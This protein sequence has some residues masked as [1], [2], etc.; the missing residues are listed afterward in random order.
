MKP[1]RKPPKPPLKPL[2]PPL[3]PQHRQPAPSLPPTPVPP[4]QQVRHQD[5]TEEKFHGLRACEALFARRSQDIIR[6]YLTEERRRQFVKLLDFCAK[7]RRGFQ[8]VAPENLQRLTGSIHHEGIAILAREI[9][10]WN[11]AELMQAIESQRLDGPLLYLDGV[12]NPHNLGTIL[13]TAA[14][15]GVAAILGAAS[16]LPSLSP[17]AVRVAEGAAECVPVCVLVDPIADLAR[18]KKAGFRVVATSSHR[19]D[20]IHAATIIKKSILVLGGEG[21]GVS[22]PID[23]IADLRLRIPGTNAVE[24][25]NVSV[26]CGIVLSEAWRRTHPA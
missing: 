6:V 2:K 11:L 3:K 10:R 12:Q 22:R 24:S 17:A 26:A 7:Q 18:L 21:E 1:P 14:H 23:A 9:P 13:R 19:G 5:K 4:G 16:D 15:F 20:P 25:L 8:I